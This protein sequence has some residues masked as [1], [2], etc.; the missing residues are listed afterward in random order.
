[1]GKVLVDCPKP[2]ASVGLSQNLL[3]YLHCAGLG[4]SALGL[5]QGFNKGCSVPFAP[6]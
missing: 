4:F 1:M 2:S 3:Y 6:K 5:T